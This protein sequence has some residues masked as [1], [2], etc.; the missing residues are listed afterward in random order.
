[1]EE[2]LVEHDWD[3]LKFNYEKLHGSIWE[4]HRISWIVTSIFIPI[5]FAMQGYFIKDYFST[6]NTAAPETATVQVFMGAFVIQSLTVVW[7]LVM[8]IFARY[9]EVRINRLRK[10]ENIFFTKK[11]G[12]DEYPVKQYK[13][14][15]TLYLFD[16]KKR[17]DEKHPGFKMTFNRV[18]NLVLVE[19]VVVNI[20]LILYSI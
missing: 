16:G 3:L 8:R 15:Y 1:M 12:D 4:N 10:I 11:M 17:P 9:N 13:Y 2:Q 20:V 7:W 14:S 18:Y 19:T 5:I 6:L